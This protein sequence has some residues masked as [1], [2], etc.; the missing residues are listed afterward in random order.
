MLRVNKV[1]KFRREDIVRVRAGRYPFAVFIGP[2]ISARE[3]YCAESTLYTEEMKLRYFARLFAE[4][5]ARGETDTTDPRH[6][7]RREIEA[8]LRWSKKQGLAESTRVRYL[9]FLENYLTWCGN[10][11][12]GEMK[13]DKRLLM[14]VNRH[15]DT[16]ISALTVEQL[17]RIMDAAESFEGWTGVAFRGYVALGFATG[18][19]QKELLGGEMQ[20][21]DLQRMRYYVR[22]PK[23]ENSWGR[24]QWIP[25]IRG[26][27]LPWL[28]DLAY[29]RAGLAASSYGPDYLFVSPRSGRPFAAQ[30]FK[31]LKEKTVQA[32]GIEW[33]LKDLRS[34]LASVT[35]AGD[36]SRLKATSLQLR[37]SSV[38]TT[39]T[40]YA[41]INSE[42]E[43]RKT[44]GNVWAREPIERHP[45]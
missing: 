45:K 3:T 29:A 43:I 26:D 42:Q 35:V 13:S 19:R 41:R 39:E 8:F 37:H 27:M 15:L 5:K 36:L 22:H 25:I 34:T 24:P 11:I 12:V 1:N 23:G 7:G 14:P 6:M 33:K 18:C 31:N 9:N 20:D 28:E 30:T 17:Q 38:K 21:L 2:F 4:M 10:G 40:Y 44:L 32:T 16:P